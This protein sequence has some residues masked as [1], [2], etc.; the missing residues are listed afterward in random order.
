MRYFPLTLLFACWISTSNSALASEST[1]QGV[2]QIGSRR[3]LFADDYLVERLAGS[4]K[5]FPK[6]PQPREIVLVTDKPWEG[7]S[8]LYFMIFRDKNLYRMYYRGLQTGDGPTA[9]QE[10]ACYA[11]S[12]DGITWRRPELNIVNFRGSTKNNIIW[13]GPGA[14]K[15]TP[16]VD[17]NPT[18]PPQARYKALG[19]GQRTPTGAAGT[20]H[21]LFAFQSPD[22][23]HWTRTNPQPIL[24]NGGFDSQNL[25]FW[26]TTRQTYLAFYRR[27]DRGVRSISTSSSKDFKNWSTS[28]FLDYRGAPRQ[29]L[30]TNAIQPYDRAPHLLIGFPTRFYPQ[31]Q[32]PNQPEWTEP[33]LIASHD[34]QSF[35]FWNKS[36]IPVD[37][38]AGRTGNRSNYLSTGL[39]PM[40]NN[41]AEYAVYASEDRRTGTSMKLRRFTYRTDGFVTVNTSNKPGHLYTKPLVFKGNRL[42]LNFQTQPQGQLQLEILD[43]AGKALPGFSLADCVPIMGDHLAKHV[44]W[45]NGGSVSQ[46]AGQPVRLHFVMQQCDLYSFQFQLQKERP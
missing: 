30:Y 23:I 21:Q 37:E 11:E 31:R 9:H 29:H 25:A 14:H 34:G 33:I 43:M 7:S 1:D 19:R 8:C 16:F 26:D 44:Q 18:C 6:K 13:A 10:V 12:H 27:G 46:L 45:R 20:V 36:V 2:I 35:R 40:T 22:G 28:R 4:T 39:V 17:R 5:I 42:S 15:F 24:T 38:G 3:E 32:F 41:P